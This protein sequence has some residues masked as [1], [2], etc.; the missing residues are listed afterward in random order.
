MG[1]I[2]GNIDKILANRFK[3]RGMSW[4]PEFSQGRT[5]DHQ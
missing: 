3:K 2:E 5:I 4:S 1:A